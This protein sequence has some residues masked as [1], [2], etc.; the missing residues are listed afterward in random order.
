M[1]RSRIMMLL[2]MI[3]NIIAI[4]V[5]A[6]TYA[7]GGFVTL[8]DSAVSNTTN[9]INIL[10]YN[11]HSLSVFGIATGMLVMSIIA[12]VR[13]KNRKAKPL[14]VTDMVLSGV[15]IVLY[16]LAVC[17][18]KGATSN[19]LAVVEMPLLINAIVNLIL[20]VIAFI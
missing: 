5:T 2:A 8:V 10:V 9:P 18:F 7:I 6:V 3:A 14:I 11:L 12:M 15:S 4:V 19:M 1:N 16:V 20:S 17:V 13:L